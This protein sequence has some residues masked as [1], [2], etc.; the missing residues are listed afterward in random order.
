MSKNYFDGIIEGLTR[1]AHW[2][3]G[4]QYVGTCGRTLKQ[5]LADV[6]M[7]RKKEEENPSGFGS[8]LDCWWDPD[9][10]NVERGHKL[11]LLNRK[12]K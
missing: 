4:V 12:L 3:D 7:E 2:K 10:C 11:C 8:C 1:Y 5:A 9:G 6:E